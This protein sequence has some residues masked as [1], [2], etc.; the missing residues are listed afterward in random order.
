MSTFVS[1]KEQLQEFVTRSNEVTRKED[2]TVSEAF[3]RLLEG[4]GSGL[5][6]VNV[7]LPITHQITVTVE[8]GV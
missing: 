3:E 6:H 7:N 4:Y 8:T 5:S 2:T 1:I